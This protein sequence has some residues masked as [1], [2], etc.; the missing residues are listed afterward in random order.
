MFWVHASNASRFEQSFHEIASRIKLAGRHKIHIDIFQLMHD[1]LSDESKRKWVL[2]LD[3]ADDAAFLVDAPSASHNGEGSGAESKRS[4][5]LIR[6]VPQSQN[7]SVLITSRS[8]AAARRLVEENGMVPIDPMKESDALV[9]LQKKLGQQEDSNNITELAAALEYMPLAMVQAA[10]YVSQRRPRFSVQ[11]Y[12]TDFRRNDHKKTSLLNS[13]GGQL[14]RDW[15]AKNSI[16]IT[17]QISFDHIRQT[18]PSASDLLSIMSFYDRQYIPHILLRNH[19]KEELVHQENNASRSIFH[20]QSE[21]EDTTLQ[22]S[23]DDSLEADILTLRDYSFIIVNADGATYDMHRLVQLATQKWL[24]IHDQLERCKGQSV[25]RLYM[26]FPLHGEYENWPRCQPLF[27][28]AKA[29]ASQQPKEESVLAEWATI[30][31][32]AA[33]YAS[34][35]GNYSEAEEISIQTVKFRTKLLGREHKDTLDS[36][37]LLSINYQDIGRLDAAETLL[38]ELVDISKRKL[39]THHP[40]TL[41]CMHLLASN[42]LRRLNW[43]KAE[44]LLIQVTDGQK[45]DF[46]VEH[47]DTISRMNNLAWAYIGQEKW[48]GAKEL[49]IQITRTGRKNLGADHLTTLSATVNLAW[50]YTNIGEYNRAETLL[51]QVVESYREK[52]GVDHPN[53]LCALDMLSETYRQQRKFDLAVELGVQVLE[54]RRMKLGVGHPSTLASMNYLAVAHMDQERWDE[55]KEL[56]EQI[57]KSGKKQKG[58]A[59]H[60]FMLLNMHNLAIVLKMQGHTSEAISLMEDCWE[61]RILVLGPQHSD[62]IRSYQWLIQWQQEIITP[63]KETVPEAT[64]HASSKTTQPK[65]NSSPQSKRSDLRQRKRGNSRER[66][67]NSSRQPKHDSIQQPKC[68]SPQNSKGYGPQQPE[69]NSLRHTSHNNSRNL[70]HDGRRQRHND[71]RHSKHDSSPPILHERKWYLGLIC[72]K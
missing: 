68:E 66:E 56:L 53:T 20:D 9:L 8:K 69:H 45:K 52:L 28:H 43:N 22:S 7:G 24:K 60:P 36:M 19:P 35:I 33:W 70:K 65:H 62:T 72:C 57:I 2:I 54:K 50:T 42:Y 64:E 4:Q 3:N 26:T 63:S 30:L 23:A 32:R 5:P 27:P 55:A 34:E 67:R 14:R 6:C 18:R 10:A 51:M 41:Y 46:G 48:S 58:G 40:D 29:I 15:E 71:P 61:Q 44:E 37:A 1:W 13:E 17:W 38:V 59:K 47:H 39:G 25:M 11:Q 21:D 49:L 12:L 31:Y 16:I